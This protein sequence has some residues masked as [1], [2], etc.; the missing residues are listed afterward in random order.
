M[1]FLGVR[2]STEKTQ[3]KNKK[4]K[5]PP[6]CHFK[7]GKCKFLVCPCRFVTPSVQLHSCRLPNPLTQLLL[8]K[9]FGELKMQE[10]GYNSV[11]GPHC[12]GAKRNSFGFN[13][14]NFLLPA[15]LLPPFQLP[16]P[17]Y[18]KWWLKKLFHLRLHSDQHSCTF[19]WAIP[20]HSLA[21]VQ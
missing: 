1:I 8:V 18:Y 10:E 19:P 3:K 13:F 21:S 11:Y 4:F 16:G 2:G 9:N 15:T 20:C 7:I 6:K 14:G 12:R 17:F 5:Y